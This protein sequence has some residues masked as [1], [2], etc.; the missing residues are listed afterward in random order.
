ML[1]PRLQKSPLQR[2]R[3]LWSPLEL[4]WLKTLFLNWKQSWMDKKVWV[5]CSCNLKIIRFSKF[6]YIKKIVIFRR[7]NHFLLPCSFVGPVERKFHKG[8]CP[9]LFLV[10]F[11]WWNSYR[12]DIFFF[13]FFFNLIPYLNLLT[14]FRCKRVFFSYSWWCSKHCRAIYYWW[15]GHYSRNSCLLGYKKIVCSEAALS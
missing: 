10:F 11:P 6:H 15:K 1:L 9:L 3:K 14:I 5:S 2:Q 12:S 13:F 4:Q 8:W 7:E